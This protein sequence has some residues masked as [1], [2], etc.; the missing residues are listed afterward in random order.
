MYCWVAQKTKEI[1]DLG[2]VRGVIFNILRKSLPTIPKVLKSG[3][4]MEMRKDISCTPTQY[5]RAVEL[6]GFDPNDYAE[7]V[8]EL[9]PFKFVHREY[10]SL[11]LSSLAPAVLEFKHVSGEMLSIMQ[12]IQKGMPVSPAV[13]RCDPLRQCSWCDYRSLCSQKLFG[14]SWKEIAAYDYVREDKFDEETDA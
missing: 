10:I 14:R 6:A 1:S 9:D 11:P 12:D 8:S 5:L 3:N 7:F 2:P 13:Y 4:G